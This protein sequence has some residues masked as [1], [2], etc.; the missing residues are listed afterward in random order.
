[1][2]FGVALMLDI[3]GTECCTDF[4]GRN[5]RGFYGIVAD[6]SDDSL[7]LPYSIDFFRAVNEKYIE[8]LWDAVK[9]D[10]VRK[11]VEIDLSGETDGLT[12]A[13]AGD[14][15][16]NINPGECLV[17]GEAEAGPAL[18]SALACG[19]DISLITGLNS[20][21]HAFAADADYDFM[22]AI[23]NGVAERE[24]FRREEPVKKAVVPEK[25]E[26]PEPYDPQSKK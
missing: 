20:K 24:V 16:L 1:M 19:M 6:A 22:N 21:Q 17:L 15:V 2:L 5:V 3:F 10:L 9:D 23:V 8:P 4:T 18:Q 14:V 26:T 12:A 13:A 7:K 25:T 11:A